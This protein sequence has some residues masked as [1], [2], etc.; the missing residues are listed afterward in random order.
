MADN[1]KKG[2]D[3]KRAKANTSTE[4]SIKK[5]DEAVVETKILADV[6]DTKPLNK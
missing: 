1:K 4:K 2:K 3:N 6:E 5:E